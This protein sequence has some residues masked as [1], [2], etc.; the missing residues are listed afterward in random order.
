MATKINQ[1]H[2]LP[3]ALRTNGL[4]RKL[5]S[6]LKFW[7]VLIR[8]PAKHG[9]RTPPDGSGSKNGAERTY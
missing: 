8:F 2:N 7:S 1:S 6:R 5:I 9:P 4:N 3:E